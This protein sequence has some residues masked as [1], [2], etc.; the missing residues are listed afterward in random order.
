MIH[1]PQPPP[2]FHGHE[3]CQSKA[4][5]DT[6]GGLIPCV[7]PVVRTLVAVMALA[8][9]KGPRHL[10][11]VAVSGRAFWKRDNLRADTAGGITRGLGRP[12][13]VVD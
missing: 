1:T 9:G 5:L 2:P 6:P 13:P 10:R 3:P 11:G 8:C 12:Y 4:A 7:V